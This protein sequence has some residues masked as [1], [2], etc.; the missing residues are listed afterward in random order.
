MEEHIA[1]IPKTVLYNKRTL[2]GI[3]ISDFKLYYKAIVLG[4]TYSYWHK[5]NRL[6]N[7]IELKTQ[8]ESHISTYEHLIFDKDKIIHWIKESIFHKWCWSNWMSTM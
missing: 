1:R 2:G 5:T 4:T 8:K 6:I 3:T 7:G